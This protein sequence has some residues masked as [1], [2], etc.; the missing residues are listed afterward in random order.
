[1]RTTRGVVAAVVAALA[2]LV[3][4]ATVPN[5][6]TIRSEDG[7]NES[8][9]QSGY[10]VLADPPKPGAQPGSV[11]R[12][13]LEAMSNPDTLNIAKQYLT[14]EAAAAWDV[15]QTRIYDPQ[16]SALQPE[17]DIGF[18]LKASLVAT[19]DARNAWRPAAPNQQLNVLF[20]VVEVDGENRISTPP[21]GVLLDRNVSE[22]NYQPHNLYFLNPTND[23][24]VPDPIYL[25]INRT[26]SQIAH[27]LMQS[28]L[29][30]PTSRLGNSVL[31]AVP[32]NT[33]LVRNVTVTDGAANVDLSDAVKNVGPVEREQLAAQ[34]AWTLRPVG[35]VRITVQGVPLQDGDND[36]RT[37]DS[38]SRYDPSVPAAD[39][40]QLYVLSKGKINRF[41]GLDGSGEIKLEPLGQAS[42]L[43]PFTATSFAISLNSELGAVVSGGQVIVARLSMAEGEKEKRLPASGKVIRPSFDWAGNLWFVDRA[44]SGPRVWMMDKEQ[45]LVEVEADFQGNEVRALRMAP[46]GVRALAVVHKNGKSALWIGRV[47]IGENNKRSLVGFHSLQVGFDDMVDAAWSKA[48]RVTVVGT[49]GDDPKSQPLEVNVDG[50]LP[51]LVA[52]VAKYNVTAVAATPNVESLLILQINDAKLQRRTRDLQWDDPLDSTNYSAVYPVYPG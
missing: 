6:G 19:L 1:M 41:M 49:K 13:F 21:P 52:G 38:F 18:R 29:A 35:P 33:E 14:A 32:P 11:V 24:L 31:S 47:Q 51:G 3:G 20:T 28:L 8:T 10:D 22:T 48:D 16:P 12:G 5:S 25:P 9:R 50:S 26:Q 23:L 4:C 15:R 27:L 45:N 40:T 39:L 42:L 37:F 34:I 30:G 44:D 2:L 43:S 17:K 36:A 46:D 7:R